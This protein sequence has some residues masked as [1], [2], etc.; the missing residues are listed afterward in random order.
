MFLAQG[1]E[2]VEEKPREQA[3]ADAEFQHK[4]VG[5][6]SAGFL[7]FNEARE[8]NFGGVARQVAVVVNDERHG[9][10]V[11]NE[12]FVAAIFEVLLAEF[13]FE[14]LRQRYKILH[15]GPAILGLAQ[16]VAGQ[17]FCRWKLCGIFFGFGEWTRHVTGLNSSQSLALGVLI[18]SCRQRRF[19]RGK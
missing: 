15:D 12:R 14:R 11:G 8:E 7:R 10:G 9:R 18:S 19:A 13:P 1:L 6:Q 17:A 2:M 4:D 16:N 3:D 5:F